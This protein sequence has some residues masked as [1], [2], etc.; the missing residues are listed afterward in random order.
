M[1][2]QVLKARGTEPVDGRPGASLSEY[3]FEKELVYLTKRYGDNDI[4]DK[5]LLSY[6]L[7]PNVYVDWKDFHSTFGEVGALPTHLFL[8]PMKVGDEVEIE[9]GP[10]KITILRLSS[11]QDIREDG[12]RVVIFE[13]NGELWYMPVTDLSAKADQVVLEKAT[14]PAKSA[15]QCPG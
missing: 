11:I 2:T 14:E 8:N 15:V 6:A 4:D 3:D 9:F 12:T 10:G 5:E 1:R 7:Y 13:V